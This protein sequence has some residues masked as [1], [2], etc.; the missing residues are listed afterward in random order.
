MDQDQSQYAWTLTAGFFGSVVSL[1]FQKKISLSTGI[2]SVVGGC[3]SAF[4]LAP[5]I[6]HFIPVQL[7]SILHAVSFLMGLLGM[8]LCRVTIKF[9]RS[10]GEDYMNRFAGKYLPGSSESDEDGVSESGN[11]P[12]DRGDQTARPT[13]EAHAAP[14]ATADAEGGVV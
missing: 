14:V 13:G 7:P 1:A 4:F 11:Q 10:R 2:I 12:G 8:E 6:V 3:A 5:T 9:V